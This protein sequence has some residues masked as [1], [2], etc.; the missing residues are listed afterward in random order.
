MNT[1]GSQKT[2]HHI[3]QYNPPDMVLGCFIGVMVLLVIIIFFLGFSDNRINQLVNNQNN[4]IAA[5]NR[6]GTA[7]GIEKAITHHKHKNGFASRQ[8]VGNSINGTM[9][10]G[11]WGNGAGFAINNTRGSDYGLGSCGNGNCANNNSPVLEII[12]ASNDPSSSSSA[13]SVAETEAKLFIDMGVMAIEDVMGS[14]SSRPP[15]M[16]R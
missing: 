4:T 5:I 14:K 12:S 16:R 9:P 10:N 6:L 1:P 7:Y 3:H 15:H 8:D 13:K 11:S 2:V